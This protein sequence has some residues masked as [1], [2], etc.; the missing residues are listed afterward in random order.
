[1]FA[2]SNGHCWPYWPILQMLIDCSADQHRKFFGAF[3]GIWCFGPLL[4]MYT[5]FIFR[6][7]WTIIN[8]LVGILYKI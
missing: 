6:L 8:G 3:N 1:M 4:Q 7:S 5:R 2:T